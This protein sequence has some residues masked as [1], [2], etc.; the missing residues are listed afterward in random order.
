M[1]ATR[2]KA[3]PIER[4]ILTSTRTV[5]FVVSVASAVAL[6]AAFPKLD[7]SWF[8]PLAMAGLFWSWFVTPARTAVLIGLLSGIVYFAIMCSWFATTAAG[9]VGPF[10]FL[11]VLGPAIIECPAFVL[12][13]AA[14]SLAYAR[15]PGVAAPFAAAGA[16]G[17][18][19]WLRSVGTMGMP[20]AQV[21][22]SQV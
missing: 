22:Y 4:N 14:A 19:E 9:L 8:A 6:T 13:A 12:A 20:F 21:G 3:K 18:F 7:W 17:L 16:F 11:T 2:Q 1:I 15:I 10:G 5:A